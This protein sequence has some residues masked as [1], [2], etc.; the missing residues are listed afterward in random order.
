MVVGPDK[1][2]F[3]TNSLAPQILKLTPGGNHTPRVDPQ[4]QVVKRHFNPGATDALA[5]D[6]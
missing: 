4:N 6:G 3:V 1:S 5:P 2:L